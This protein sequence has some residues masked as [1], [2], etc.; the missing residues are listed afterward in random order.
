MIYSTMISKDLIFRLAHSKEHRTLQS[1]KLELLRTITLPK[2]TLS[3]AHSHC[4]ALKIID[5]GITVTLIMSFFVTPFKA[6]NLRE[7]SGLI[8]SFLSAGGDGV[9]CLLDVISC[10]FL[11]IYQ[12]WLSWDMFFVGFG[13]GQDGN[14][15]IRLVAIITFAI[16]P[17]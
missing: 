6:S 15:W 5:I 10:L 13:G 1:S 14:S 16:Q 8:A 2:C 11:L 3:L 7:R 4:K 17:H 12:K 9:V